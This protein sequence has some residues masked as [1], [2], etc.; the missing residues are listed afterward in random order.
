MDTEMIRK[1]QL[2]RPPQFQGNE[3]NV[4]AALN[5]RVLDWVTDQ[6]GYFLRPGDLWVNLLQDQISFSYLTRQGERAMGRFA[7]LIKG[8]KITPLNLDVS[9]RRTPIQRMIT[10]IETQL[11]LLEMTPPETLDRWHGEAVKLAN[12]TLLE[13]MLSAAKAWDQ[14]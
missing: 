8:G 2:T 12:K 1:F 14:Q 11:D 10:R 6:T 9:E 3:H 7:D 4:D 5:Q 13:N